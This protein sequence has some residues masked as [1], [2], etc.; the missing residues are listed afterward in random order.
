MIDVDALIARVEAAREGG[1]DG[2]PSPIPILEAIQHDAASALVEAVSERK[3]KA[4]Y[5]DHFGCDAI[6]RRVWRAKWTHDEAAR[7]I[8]GRRFLD[9]L[10]PQPQT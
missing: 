7:L 1:E 10:T 3:S 5:L 9:S 4:D 6:S 2:G 8:T